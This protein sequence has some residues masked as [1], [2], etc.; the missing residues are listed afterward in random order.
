MKYHFGPDSQDDWVSLFIDP[1]PAGSEPLTPDVI[2][3]IA[4][5]DDP[6]S[7][8]GTLCL[9]QG[10]SMPGAIID[11]IRIA[12]TWSDGSL[13]V[14]LVG[15]EL[16]RAGKTVIAKWKTISETDNAGFYVETEGKMDRGWKTE[17]FVAGAGTSTETHAYQFEIKNKTGGFKVRLRQ[18]DADGNESYSGV[19]VAEGEVPSEFSISDAYPNPFNPTTSLMVYM[20]ARGILNIQVI[21]LLGRKIQQIKTSELEPGEHSVNVDF[22]GSSSGVYFIKIQFG[23]QILVKKVQLVR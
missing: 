2:Y 9:R 5:I 18:V 23:K 8:L 16:I 17:G 13:P 1:D 7:G 22:S 6:V 12:T 4:G 19:L 14:E 11:G 10:S 3:N 20:P 15:F 21:D